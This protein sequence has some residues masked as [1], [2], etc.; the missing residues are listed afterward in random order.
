MVDVRVPVDQHVPEARP[1]PQPFGERFLQGPGFVQDSEGVAV[2]LRRPQGTIGD[3]VV[4]QVDCRLGSQVQMA[5]RE[6]VDGRFRQEGILVDLTQT[7]SLDQV[8]SNA[9]SRLES[10]SSSTMGR[11]PVVFEPC[12]ASP[13]VFAEPRREVLILAHRTD[14]E[15]DPFGLVACV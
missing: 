10:I 11:P 4:C 9:S 2:G 5:L 13:P 1:C 14:R 6:V 8:A 12:N 3:V 15:T 7:F